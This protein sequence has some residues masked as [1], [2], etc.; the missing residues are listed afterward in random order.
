MAAANAAA[1]A[2]PAAPAQP[3]PP[4]TVDIQTVQADNEIFL[5][6]DVDEALVVATPFC[7][8]RYTRSTST[9]S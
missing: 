7:C 8:H 1:A 6:L 4:I 3:L 9:R 5:L 2:L